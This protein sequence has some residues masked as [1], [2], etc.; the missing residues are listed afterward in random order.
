MKGKTKEV[1]VTV[2]GRTVLEGFSAETCVKLLSRRCMDRLLVL[3]Q[4]TDAAI[5][6]F[7]YARRQKL[8]G[9]SIEEA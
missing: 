1:K 2:S 6:D 5:L 8:S 7:T 9:Q 4:R 3:A